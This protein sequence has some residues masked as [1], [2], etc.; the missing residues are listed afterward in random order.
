MWKFRKKKISFQEDIEPHEILLDSLVQRKEKE[1]GSSERKL[2]VPLLKKIL[3]GF[4]LCC[5]LI[6]FLLFAK[7]FQFQVVEGKKYAEMAAEQYQ[8]RK[9]C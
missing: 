6:I 3:Q 5:F 8:F 9:A 1:T 7:T 4:F 2:E